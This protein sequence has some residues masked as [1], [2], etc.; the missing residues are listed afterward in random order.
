MPNEGKSSEGKSSA[1]GSSSGDVAEKLALW[2]TTGSFVKELEVWLNDHCSA[3]SMKENEDG[4]SPLEWGSIFDKYTH[5][6]D[7]QLSSFCEQE[8]VDANEVYESLEGALSEKGVADFLPEF[9]RNTD[10]AEFSMQMK[11]RAKRNEA[12][13]EA[14]DL[15]ADN[16]AC[17]LF[18]MSGVWK[19]DPSTYDPSSAEKIMKYMGCPWV[20]STLSGFVMVWPPFDF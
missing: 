2:G 19:A 11:E 20:C 16:N 17:D 6:L 3:F 12:M 7:G 10:F 15:A 1:E 14:R 9:M 4:S 18:N 5:W 13:D 8:N